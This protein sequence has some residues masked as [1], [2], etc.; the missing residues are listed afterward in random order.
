MKEIL[1]LG[2]YIYLNIGDGIPWVQVDQPGQVFHG[3]Q[4]HPAQ[5]QTEENDINL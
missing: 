1:L 5:N 4:G 2:A 3:D